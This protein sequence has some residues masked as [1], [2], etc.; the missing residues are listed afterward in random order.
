MTSFETNRKICLRQQTG[1]RKLLLEPGQFEH[2]IQLFLT[3]HAILHSA[4]MSG[5]GLWSFEDAILNDLP[6][7]HFRRIP[8]NEEHSI[9]WLIWHMARCEDI[10]LNLLVAGR[11]Q[12]LL[13]DGWL[14]AV[15]GSILHTGNAMT[16]AEIKAFSQAIDLSALRLYRQT[17]GRRTRE[18]VSQLQPGDLKRK[19]E[20][21]RI[22]QVWQ[23]GAV[24]ETARDIVD[25]WSKRDVAGLLLMPATRHNLVHLNEALELKTRQS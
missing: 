4:Q 21:Q 2:G 18:I 9:A 23:Q 14:E 8:P 24:L 1:L 10:T 17:V 7:V 3:Q 25:Y 20:P 12:V 13:A 15:G 16:Q 11:P 22:K 19:V 6:E 5:L